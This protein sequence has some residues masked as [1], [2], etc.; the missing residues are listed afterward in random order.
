MEMI[1]FSFG[2]V[3]GLVMGFFAVMWLVGKV[4]G[5]VERRD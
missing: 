3:I 2:A 1:L 5:E 4:V